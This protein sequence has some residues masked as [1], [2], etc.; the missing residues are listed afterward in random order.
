MSVVKGE[1]HLQGKKT[2]VALA[3]AAMVAL[4]SV[5]AFASAPRTVVGGPTIVKLKASADGDVRWV[6]PGVRRLDPSIFGTAGEPLREELLPL[7]ARTVRDGVYQTKMPGPFGDMAKPI[8]GSAT[9]KVKDLTSV[10]GPMTEDEIEAEFRFTSPDGA[11]EYRVV[12]EQALPQLPDHENFGGVGINVVQHGRTGIG[13]AL[14][15]QVMAFVT[16]WGPAT[17]YVDGE[18]VADNRFVHFMLTERVRDPEG[19]YRLA[20]D[21]E[22]DHDSMHAHLILPPVI[23]TTGGPQDSAVPTGFQLPMGMGEQPFLHIMFENMKVKK[24]SGR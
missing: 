16:F 3:V 21:D 15:P 11:H 17:F 23:V 9:I 24:V 20:F 14:M 1:T 12:V 10:A 8:T 7:D 5:V 22:V 6:M 13:T 4:T 18:K 2:F 19:D